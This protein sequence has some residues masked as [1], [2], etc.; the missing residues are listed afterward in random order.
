VLGSSEDD[1]VT[2]NKGG[3]DVVHLGS[4][5]DDVD[6]KRSSVAG[7]DTISLGRG[8][9]SARLVGSETRALLKGAGG[10]DELFLLGAQ[11][12]LA[13][14]IDTRAGTATAGGVVRARWSHFEVFDMT[15]L[16]TVRIRFTGTDASERLLLHETT[17]D[18]TL[19]GG[20]DELKLEAN[21]SGRARGGAGQDLIGIQGGGDLTADLD[22]GAVAF[23]GP[24]G[25][26]GF[27]AWGF[28]NLRASFFGTAHLVGDQHA[29]RIQAYRVC[30][31]TMDGAGGDDSMLMRD[32]ARGCDGS[33]GEQPSGGVAMNG[34]PGDD[35]MVGAQGTDQLRGDGG[36]D[37]ADGREGIDT[38]VAETEA[39][40]ELD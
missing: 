2:L 32:A 19:G 3:R 17:M 22:T 8:D 14:H 25:D 4:G 16:Q 27:N 39:N 36:N 24:D 26:G 34:G 38:C 13:W 20:D 23:N 29:N 10:R 9:D 6:L 5:D 21:V 28:D 35:T 11:E 15:Y 30:H 18:V 31:T 37:D 12:P 40:C 7:R 1:T 33:D